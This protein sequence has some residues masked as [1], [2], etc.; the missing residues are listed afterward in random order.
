M[1]L[2]QQNAKS[3]TDASFWVMFIFKNSD[4]RTL[5]QS[6]LIDSPIVIPL[7]GFHVFAF[8]ILTSQFLENDMFSIE[9]DPCMQFRS[10]KGLEETLTF[11]ISVK[12]IFTSSSVIEYL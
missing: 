3:V 7:Y 6:S 2:K 8:F 11:K 5:D 9:M 4:K 10:S 1:I 12:R